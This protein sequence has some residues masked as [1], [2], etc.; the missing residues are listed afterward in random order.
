MTA[1]TGCPSYGEMP[2][3]ENCADPRTARQYIKKYYQKDNAAQG[4]R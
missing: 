2:L 1:Y 3:R 4:L